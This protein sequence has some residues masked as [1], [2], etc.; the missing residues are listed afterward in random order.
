[1][2]ARGG[3]VV[4]AEQNTEPDD[5]AEIHFDLRFSFLGR[6]NNNIESVC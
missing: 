3:S 2:A 4:W 6:R 1:M 5:A